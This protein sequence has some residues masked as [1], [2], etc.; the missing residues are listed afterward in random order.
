MLGIIKEDKFRLKIA[1]GKSY[2]FMKPLKIK[3]D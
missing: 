2:I 3:F 1:R